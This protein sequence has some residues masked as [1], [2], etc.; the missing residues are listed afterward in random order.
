NNFNREPDLPIPDNA[1]AGISDTLVINSDATIEKLGVSV[2]I[3]HSYVGDMRI[4]LEHVDTGNQVILLDRPGGTFCDGD[5]IVLTLDDAA[6]L[7]IQDDCMSN[8]V[9]PAYFLNSIYRPHQPLSIFNGR[10]LNGEWRLTLSDNGPFDAGHLFQWA[11]LPTIVDT[12][13]AANA[14]ALDLQGNVLPTEAAFA[15][16]AN[17]ESAT[18]T[19]PVSVSQFDTL[20]LNML[21]QV[22]PAD[23][24]QPGDALIVVLY[25]SPSGEVL[26]FTRQGE[27][28]WLPWDFTIETLQSAGGFNALPASFN[29]SIYQ[30]ALTGFPGTY[31]FFIAYRTADKLVV[32]LDTPIMLVV[33]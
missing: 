1:A 33:L 18:D 22:D 24:G 29:T 28:V 32:G 8:N 27:N 3:S 17:L 21:T 10:S 31:S 20:D 7:S 19:E 14:M 5:D 4:I 30:G 26:T 12:T 16:Q 23:I 6:E 9:G 2:Q 13:L 15:A 11:L 25:Q